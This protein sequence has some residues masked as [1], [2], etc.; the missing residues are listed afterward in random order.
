MPWRGRFCPSAGVRAGDEI[1]EID[2]APLKGLGLEPVLDKLRGQAGTT[3][4]LKIARKDQA[5]IDVAIVRE[6][7]RVPGAR[8]RVQVVDG[9]LAVVATGRWAVLDFEKDKPVLVKA[10]SATEFHT[11]V[12]DRTR[13]A[14]VRD[15]TGKVSGVVLN[16]GPW[17]IKAAKV[18]R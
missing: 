2:G 1:T 18:D 5:A 15:Q 14:F 12:G 6:P 9:A 13:L 3:V 17:E 4:R 8:I 11:D 10:T 7:I 16:P